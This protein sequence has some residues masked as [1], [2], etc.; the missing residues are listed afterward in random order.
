MWVATGPA[1]AAPDGRA[2]AE[3]AAAERQ[4]AWQ[5]LGRFAPVEVQPLLEALEAAWQDTDHP[6]PEQAFELEGPRGDVLAQAELAWPEERL[7]VVSDLVD[8]EAFTAADWRCW[9]L[10]DSPGSTAAALAE[11]LTSC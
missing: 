11:A 10:E 2:A 5:E 8:A 9:A 6:L 4:R 7:A 3:S 1:K